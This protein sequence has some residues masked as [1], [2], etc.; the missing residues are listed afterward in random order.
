VVYLLSKKNINSRDSL[1][2]SDNAKTLIFPADIPSA[3]RG[4]MGKK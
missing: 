2:S 3:I 4:L 1:S